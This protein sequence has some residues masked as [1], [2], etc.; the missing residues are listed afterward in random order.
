MNRRTVFAVTRER[1]GRT[2]HAGWRQEADVGRRPKQ[3]AHP[4]GGQQIEHLKQ[5]GAHFV[6]H[7]EMEAAR[8]RDPELFNPTQ[9]TA[10][11]EVTRCA[12]D[13]RS[14]YNAGTRDENTV[15]V[16]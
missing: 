15:P 12:C 8:I 4:H 16:G 7:T 9:P 11:L 2:T 10:P 5:K 1:A 3:K 6:L 14:C 13:N